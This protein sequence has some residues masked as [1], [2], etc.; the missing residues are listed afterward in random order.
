[1]YQDSEIFDIYDE[2]ANKI[3][4]EYRGIVPSKRFIS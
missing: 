3:G 4:Q 1:M 2:N